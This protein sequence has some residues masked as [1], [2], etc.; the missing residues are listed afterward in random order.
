MNRY[1]END[2]FIKSLDCKVSASY[3]QADILLKGKILEAL[4]DIS[5]SLAIIADENMKKSGGRKE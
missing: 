1:E 3:E 5:K 4:A 2:Q